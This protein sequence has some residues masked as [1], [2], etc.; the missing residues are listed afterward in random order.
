MIV[1][2]HSDLLMLCHDGTSYWLTMYM[3]L[4]REGKKILRIFVE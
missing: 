2:I 1:K 3:L 4:W